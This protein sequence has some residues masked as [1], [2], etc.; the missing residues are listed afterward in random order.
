MEGYFIMTES[1]HQEDMIILNLLKFKRL[2]I[3]LMSVSSTGNLT[4]Y[5]AIGKVNC[6]NS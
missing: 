4:S 3:L 5:I 2:T 6:Y 1:I